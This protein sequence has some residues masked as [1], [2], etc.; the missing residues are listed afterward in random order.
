M[1]E[2]YIV[3]YSRGSYD[4]YEEINIFATTSLNKAQKYVKKFNSIHRKWKDY[5]K[6]Y[7]DSREWIKDEFVH[8]YFDRWNELREINKC[9]I[10]K[11][12]VR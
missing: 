5:Y 4:D 1:K 9:S 3:Y 2:I 10:E 11:L 12:D 7:E 8:H 6:Q